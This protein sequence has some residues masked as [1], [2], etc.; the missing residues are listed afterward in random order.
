MTSVPPSFFV[1]VQA[2]GGVFLVLFFFP[3]MLREIG[4]YDQPTRVFRL[5]NK[6]KNL[7]TDKCSI[8]FAF[9]LLP[10]LVLMLL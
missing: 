6:T 4:Q 5:K 7:A 10:Q 9:F 2:S 1:I 3:P 8:A